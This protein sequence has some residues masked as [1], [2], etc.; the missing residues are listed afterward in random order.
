MASTTPSITVRFIIDSC[1]VVGSGGTVVCAQATRDE[2]RPR[3]ITRGSSVAN[4][5]HAARAIA[6]IHAAGRSPQGDEKRRIPATF[7]R[8][9]QAAAWKFIPGI[10]RT[11]LASRA[12]TP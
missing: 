9:I 4:E 1:V 2:A 5:D 3:R 7:P 12:W 11:A 6:F 8:S 10:I